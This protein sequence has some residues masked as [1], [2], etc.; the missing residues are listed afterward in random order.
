MIV[1]VRSLFWIYLVVIIGG[2]V[3]WEWDFFVVI[4]FI[5]DVERRVEI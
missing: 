1:W 4:V 5:N 3:F 2:I